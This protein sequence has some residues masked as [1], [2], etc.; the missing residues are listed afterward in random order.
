SRW[1]HTLTRS[2]CSRSTRWMPSG[3]T[4]ARSRCFS[5]APLFG[6]GTLP[7]GGGA[8][9]TGTATAT[10][11]AA[12]GAAAGAG[13]EAATGADLAA[14]AAAVAAVG[15]G[16]GSEGGG[17]A[18]AL[19]APPAVP[20]PAGA[21]SEP[22]AAGR[23]D[24]GRSRAALGHTPVGSLGELVGQDLVEGLLVERGVLSRH[25]LL[26]PSYSGPEM[27]PSLRIRQ[28][29]TARKITSTNGSARTCSTYQRSNV[30]GPTTTPPIRRKLACLAM[31]GEYPARLVPTVT[32]Q[33]ASWSHGRRYPVNERPSVRNSR[34][35][36]TT[37]LNSR[38]GL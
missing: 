6:S 32:A 19:P 12:A 9:R 7:V 37:Q 30:F 22:V 33:I 26:V 34:I 5:G 10:A 28:K 36:P 31:N 25:R 15:G 1:G 21:A 11:A 4:S 2:P 35:T 13:A 3:G 8:S 18:E 14:G 20:G 38:G 24:G 16:A 27:P 17:G 29:C 23:P